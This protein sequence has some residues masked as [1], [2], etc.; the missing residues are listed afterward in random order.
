VGEGKVD[1]LD[2]G[3]SAHGD[4]YETEG[5]KR[6]ELLMGQRIPDPPADP[7]VQIVRRTLRMIL[8]KRRRRRCRCRFRVARM[9]GNV[10]K[11]PKSVIV[12][13]A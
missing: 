5:G 1:N 2:C 12:P 8:T 3:V 4:L 13:A 6:L 10:L 9:L 7:K 11:S